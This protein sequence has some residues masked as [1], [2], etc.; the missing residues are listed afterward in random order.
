MPTVRRYERQAEVRGLPGV[1]KSSAATAASEG[2]G[3]ERAKADTS[4]S[5]AGFGER[6][7]QFGASL[8]ADIKHAEREAAD[9]T[10]LMEASNGLADWKTERVFNTETGA[11]MLKGKAALGLPEQLRTEFDAVADTIDKGLSTPKQRAAFA[12]LRSQE[13]QGLDLQVRRH[14]FGEMQEYRAGELKGLIDNTVNSAMQNANDPKLVAV[15]LAKAVTAIQTNGPRA[16]LGPEAVETQIRAVQSTVH[17]GV[18]S[19]LL[20]QEKD[21]DAQTYYAAI[22]GQ[23][24]GDK[25]DQVLAALAVGSSRGDG[26]KAADAI[27]AA[28]GTLKAQLEK[29][30]ALPDKVR[31]VAEQRIRVADAEADEA[32]RETDAESLNEAYAIINKTGDVSRIPP[33][34]QVQLA[35]HMP[36]LRAF[37]LSRARG[38]PVQTDPAIRYTLWE[39]AGS[40]PEAFL[41]EDLL[42]YR[43]QLDDQDLAQLTSL[44]HSIKTGDK[45]A[46]KELAGF[47]TNDQIFKDTIGDVDPTTPAVATLRR[48]LDRRVEAAQLAAGNK[49]LRN[50]EIQEIADN[51]WQSVILKPG[52]IGSMFRG[53]GYLST[54]KPIRDLRIQDIPAADLGDIQRELRR[55]GVKITNEA[56]LAEYV[57]AK[58]RVGAV[59]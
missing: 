30:K 56:V 27:V 5:R 54:V 31:E 42:A 57:R 50:S 10:A 23:I 46:D 52:G 17:V 11:L 25:K 26:I 32:K 8:Y 18:I 49:P 22:E 21:Q 6:V 12:R 3:L 36:A 51:L 41:Q 43:N 48:E 38:V 1:R 59:K 40:D 2:A 29:T 34:Q 47:R 53:E 20:A 14:V 44:R 39:M 33:L 19:T 28:G 13:W 4:L 15:D 7:T 35:T 58:R 45:K 55:A 16:G 24:A 9:E 37:A